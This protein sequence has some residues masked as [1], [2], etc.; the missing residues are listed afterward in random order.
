MAKAVLGRLTK[1]LEDS[2]F[3]WQLTCSAVSSLWGCCCSES[4]DTAEASCL[5][6]GRSTPVCFP[7]APPAASVLPPAGRGPPLTHG[8][9]RK[10]DKEGKMWNICCVLQDLPP[11][12]EKRKNIYFQTRPSVRQSAADTIMNLDP[13]LLAGFRADK[14]RTQN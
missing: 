8:E 2:P 10:R 7:P 11:T 9:G 6:L 5:Q 1:R 3:E 13:I 12:A 14:K 4:S